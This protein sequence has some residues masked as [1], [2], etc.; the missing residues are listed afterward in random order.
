MNFPELPVQVRGLSKRYRK[1]QALTDVNLDL[2]P[3]G[4]VGLVGRNGAGKSTLL[5]HLV[6]LLAPTSGS[7]RTLGVDSLRLGADQLSRIGY[8]DQDSKLIDWMSVE[9]LIRYVAAMQPKWDLDLER[10]LRGTLELEERKKSVAKLSPGMRQRL[11]LLLAVCHRP[12]VL[13]LDEPASALDPIARQDAMRLILDRAIEDDATVVVS[14]HVLHDLE[15]IIDRVVL[16]EGGRIAVDESLDTLQEGHAEWIVRDPEGRLPSRFEEPFVLSSR[17][18]SRQQQLCVRAGMNELEPFRQRH[19]F[20][21][22]ARSLDL[23]RLY[24]LLASEA[25]EERS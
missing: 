10:S 19:G 23:E 20:E 22:E 9:S 13:V 18:D 8:V 2:H 4:I 7:V 24:P 17:G 21:V 11:A 3:G 1:T 14:S 25:R 12:K 6:G 16:L 15:K 5:G